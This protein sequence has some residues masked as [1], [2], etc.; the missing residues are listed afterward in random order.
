M[1]GKLPSFQR[2]H[3]LDPSVRDQFSFAPQCRFLWHPS[4]GYLN[5]LLK[6]KWEVSHEICGGYK[7]DVL[8]FPPVQVGGQKAVSSVCSFLVCHFFA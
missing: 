3:V 5:P 2:S 7:P 4:P 8:F 1:M 6:M